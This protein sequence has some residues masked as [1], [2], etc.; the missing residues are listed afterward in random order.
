LT[1]NREILLQSLEDFMQETDARLTS[2]EA[3]PQVPEPAVDWKAFAA[4]A[5]DENRRLTAEVERLTVQ[6]NNLAAEVDDLRNV[7]AGLRKENARLTAERDAAKREVA[8]LLQSNANLSDK[9]YG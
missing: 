2:L 1:V 8:E 7:N 5:T 6:R 4:K 9:L 3:K